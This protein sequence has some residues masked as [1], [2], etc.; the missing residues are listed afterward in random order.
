MDI[1]KLRIFA[2][3]A[4]VG[5]FTRAA[6]LLY[7]TQPTISQQIATL[8]AQYDDLARQGQRSVPSADE[9]GAAVERFLAERDDEGEGS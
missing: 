1:S 7:L 3:V 8:E 4:R 2:T 6:E 5:T 9:I